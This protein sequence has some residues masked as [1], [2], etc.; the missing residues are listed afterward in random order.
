MVARRLQADPVGSG[1]GAG[2]VRGV[3]NQRNGRPQRGS[4]A[5]GEQRA[6]ADA[7]ARCKIVRAAGITCE[8]MMRTNPEMCRQDRAVKRSPLSRVTPQI[9]RVSFFEGP[10]SERL[11]HSVLLT[12]NQRGSSLLRRKA[13]DWSARR[14]C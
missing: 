6:F 1:A 12:L 13:G 11:K 10:Q 9:T 5:E 8:P 2:Y 3:Q 7:S 4:R 14:V